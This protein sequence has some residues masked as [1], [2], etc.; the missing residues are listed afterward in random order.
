MCSF[1]QSSIHYFMNITTT[2]K[3]TKSFSSPCVIISPI[4]LQVKQSLLYLRERIGVPRDMS[5]HGARQFR[6][7]INWF[8]DQLE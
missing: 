7:H 3:N 5:V 2:L 1:I 8:I 4:S 6:A